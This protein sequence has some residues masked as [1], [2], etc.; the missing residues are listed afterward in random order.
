MKLPFEPYRIKM[1]EPLG[2]T[3]RAD[4]ERIIADARY[5][6]FR[7]RSS[8]ILIDLFTDSGTGTM[9][10]DA[11]SALM[12]GDEAYAGARSWERFERAVQRIFGFA[13]V[14][15]V[16]QGRAGERILFGQLVKPGQ[17]VPNNTHF[18]TTRANL[19]RLG[20]VAVDL[21]CPSSDSTTD[22]APFKGDMDVAGLR[23]LLE[24]EGPQRVPFIMLTVT[25][26]AGG[27]QPV[28]LHNLRAV[29]DVARRY[30]IPLYL[31]ACRFAEN[32]WF[33]KAREPRQGDRSVRE[34]VAEMFSLVD[35]CTMSAKKDG[36]S[37]I[38]GF[39]GLRDQ[40]VYDRC[41]ADLLVTEGFPT[42]GGLAGRDLEAIAVGLEEAL[43]ED[44]L[45]HR[46]ELVAFLADQL[47][48]RGIPVLRPPGGH[49]VYVDARRFVPHIPPLQYPAQALCVELYLEAGVRASEIGSV[50]YG[51]DHHT[52]QE[53]PASKELMRLA[54]PRR[55]YTASHL[56]YVVEALERIWGRRES[57]RGLK[58]IGADKVLRHFRAEFARVD[59]PVE[60]PVAPAAE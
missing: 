58:I 45:R 40:A 10:A 14:M 35:G 27:G 41:L 48:A 47:H 8:E 6:L 37:N 17:L 44:Y 39:V 15:P 23:R 1:V 7:V 51:F 22:E 60:A 50:M 42:Y 54:L 28:S 30:G 2:I 38:G 33:I 26:N 16:H 11:W 52:G 31:D 4:R 19:E 43:D 25:N 24:E 29:S 53:R 46:T 49:A 18:D 9:S 59:E 36:I 5:S 13:H 55:T 57:I 3:T 21:P 56:S 20:A 34:I 12:R 32:A